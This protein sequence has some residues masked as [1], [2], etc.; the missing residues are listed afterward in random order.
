MARGCNFFA[1]VLAVSLGHLRF[2]VQLE[3]LCSLRRRLFSS[4]SV[5]LPKG[6]QTSQIITASFAN[7]QLGKS[8]GYAQQRVSTVGASHVTTVESAETKVRYAH[9]T[10]NSLTKYGFQN[11]LVKKSKNPHFL[12]D[13]SANAKLQNTSPSTQLP[14]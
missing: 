7:S 9:P 11:A 2:N 1:A 6:R 4:E 14:S 10:F 13:L 3:C 12:S 5:T 8:C